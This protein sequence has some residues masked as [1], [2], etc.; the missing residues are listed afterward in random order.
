MP[1]ISEKI[2]NLPISLL[3]DALRV[4]VALASSMQ[5]GVPLDAALDA[6]VDMVTDRAQMLNWGNEV[7]DWAAQA[8]PGCNLQTHS[9]AYDAALTWHEGIVGHDRYARISAIR[10]TDAQFSAEFV[11]DDAQG[12]PPAALEAFLQAWRAQKP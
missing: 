10:S 2:D 4:W 5:D 1:A 11:W 9:S 12:P 7:I 3:S 6:T 8:M